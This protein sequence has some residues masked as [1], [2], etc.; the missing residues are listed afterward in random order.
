MADCCAGDD[1][2]EKINNTSTTIERKP[3]VPILKQSTRKKKRKEKKQF[4]GFS[5]AVD[6]GCNK[7]EKGLRVV[8]E[9]V[10]GSF[11]CTDAE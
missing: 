8:E 4:R 1:P 6:G 9:R 3:K 11:N 5:L 2:V 7:T 10:P